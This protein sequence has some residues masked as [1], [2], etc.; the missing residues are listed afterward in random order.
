M[1]PAP[2]SIPH[3]FIHATQLLQSGQND[4]A[5]GLLHKI[6]TTDPSQTKAALLLAR[7]LL[8]ANHLSM[9]CSVLQNSQRHAQ[10]Q[11]EYLH[12]LSALQLQ[13]G[14]PDLALKTV[15]QALQLNP[16]AIA[17][18]TVKGNVLLELGRY[19]DCIDIFEQ[20]I[21]SDPDAADP[22]NNIAWAFRALGN[23][24]KAIEHFKRTYALDKNIT[25]A[26]SGALLLQQNAA[27]SPELIEALSRLKHGLGDRNKEVDLCF[28]IGKAFEDHKNY[29]QAYEFFRK[30]NKAYRSTYD[31]DV[32][33]D[34]QLF[35]AL[36]IP[37]QKQE[38]PAK[39]ADQPTPIFVL[40]MPRSSTSLVEQI[41]A[42]H[43]QVHGAGELTE[44]TKLAFPNAKKP[45]TDEIFQSIREQYLSHLSKLAKGHPYVVDKMPQNFRLIGVILNCL[46]EAK[47]IHCTRDARDN[48]LS[49]YKHHF[50]MTHH[51]YAYQENELAEYY[52][53]YLAF[54]AHWRQTQPDRFLDFSYESLVEN[55]E[56][57]VQRLL[58]YV[59]L[60]YEE[61]C[62][63]FQ[64]TQ[65][66]IRTASSDQVRRGL[67]RSGMAQWKHYSP[68]L[69]HFFEQLSR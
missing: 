26:L 67:Y 54:M 18:L 13:T 69:D 19:E 29:E 31:Y 41:L 64:N 12:M 55:F 40:G 23:K 7:L 32:H 50:P 27:D 16:K 1:S 62:V 63:H 5:A 14:S 15:D 3:A 48:G 53:E 47:I 68:M 20:A 39:K 58:E 42:S 35:E 44:L 33:Q 38:I 65:R 28:A 25:E 52:H 10:G 30:G 11:F 49:L 46:P 56:P 61:S 22:H 6:V 17:T 24:A 43:S 51:P 4:Q 37:V 8:K 2:F 21:L 45:W 57:N 60:P 9:A 34:K 66:A 36:K 59:G